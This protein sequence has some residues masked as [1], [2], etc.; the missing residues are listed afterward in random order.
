[1]SV[2]V[3]CVCVCTHVCV[4]ALLATAGTKVQRC[5]TVRR[6]RHWTYEVKHDKKRWVKSKGARPPWGHQR[7][8]TE[9]MALSVQVLGPH[10][11]GLE[12]ESSLAARGMGIL[13]LS[14]KR[15][16]RAVV[17][18]ASP[19]HTFSSNCHSN[20]TRRGRS[21]RADVDTGHRGYGT[22]R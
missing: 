21:H 12:F 13:E 22:R 18:V 16:R 8:P 17:I 9:Q 15:I 2:S 4:C 3:G 11:A 6:C 14:R 1:M 10:S 7:C 5:E 20:P 19:S